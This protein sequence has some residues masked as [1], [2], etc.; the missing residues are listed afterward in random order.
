MFYKMKYNLKY[1]HSLF[2]AIPVEH[3]GHT[4]PDQVPP[5]PLVA[6]QEEPGI[7]VLRRPLLAPNVNVNV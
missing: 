2:A 3:S 7:G 6:V 1:I 5:N 4:T